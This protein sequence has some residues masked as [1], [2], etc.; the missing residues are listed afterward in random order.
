MA[1][2]PCKGSKHKAV[3][4]YLLYTAAQKPSFNLRPMSGWVAA[5]RQDYPWGYLLNCKKKKCIHMQVQL[6][7]H[8]SEI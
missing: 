3:R 4:T 2:A 8:A 7:Y 6:G 5:K 1:G